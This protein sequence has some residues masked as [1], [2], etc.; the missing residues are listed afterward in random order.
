MATLLKTN[1]SFSTPPPTAPCSNYNYYSTFYNVSHLKSNPQRSINLPRLFSTDSSSMKKHRCSK[2]HKVYDSATPF[3]KG[4]KR[5]KMCGNCRSKKN[6]WY[7]VHT[8]KQ[9]REKCVGGAP[10]IMHTLF[11]SNLT[12]TSLQ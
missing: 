9:S 1:L 4:L 6:Q 2:C 11:T 5:L 8:F 3:M 10:N 12:H 7:R